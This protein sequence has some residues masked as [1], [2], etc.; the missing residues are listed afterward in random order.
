MHLQFC[1][2]V[3]A[4]IFVL[5]R[6]KFC[7]LL[8]LLYHTKIKQ[9]GNAFL[10]L[11]E[12]LVNQERLHVAS[13]DPVVL[14]AFLS[15]SKIHRQMYDMLHLYRGLRFLLEIHVCTLR[16]LLLLLLNL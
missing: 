1:N 14:I 9:D 15:P 7:F 11:L 12:I 2:L 4:P 6:S 13:V 8:V 5:L 3:I 10:T 16:N